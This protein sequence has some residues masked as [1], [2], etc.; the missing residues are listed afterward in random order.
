MGD[1]A[2]PSSAGDALKTGFCKGF[3]LVALDVIGADNIE[4]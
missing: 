3:D 2:I 4:L 1:D